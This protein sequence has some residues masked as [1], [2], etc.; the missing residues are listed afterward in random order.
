MYISKHEIYFCNRNYVASLHMYK[1]I[2]I[3]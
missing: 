3:L 2:I 1:V